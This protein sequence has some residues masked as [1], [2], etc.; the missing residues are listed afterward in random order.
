MTFKIWNKDTWSINDRS[1]VKSA[2]NEENLRANPSY[3]HGFYWPE[4]DKTDGQTLT[5]T[6]DAYLPTDKDYGENDA[7]RPQNLK[8]A[9]H[10]AEQ[11][12]FDTKTG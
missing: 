9:E 6:E 2:L 4:D 3:N 11:T 7:G 12:V 5:V 8:F 1:N 10:I